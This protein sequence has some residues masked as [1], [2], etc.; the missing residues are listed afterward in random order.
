MSSYITFTFGLLTGLI[1]GFIAIAWLKAKYQALE[2]RIE[3]LHENILSSQEALATQQNENI[4]LIKTIAKLEAEKVS[5]E[6][7]LVSHQEKDKERGEKLS[8]QFNKLANELLKQ[9]SEK[10]VIENK[11]QI[12]SL[13]VPLKE[14]IV[15]FERQIT[16]THE[17]T[18]ARNIALRTELK[19]IEDLNLQITQEA[20]NL[21]N[22]IKGDNKVQGNWGEFILESLL[23]KSGLVKDREYFIQEAFITSEGKRYRPDVVIKLPD[24]KNIVIDAK[25]SLVNYEKCCN[26]ED[27]QEQKIYAKKHVHSIKTHIKDLSKKNYAQEYDLKGLDFVLM[28]IPIEPAYLLAVKH[29]TELFQEAYQKNI[30]LVTPSTLM[31]LLRMIEHTWKTD[32]QNKNA[33]EIARYSG[34]LFDKFVSFTE[35]IK[36]V[37]NQLNTTQKTYETAIKQLSE[38]KGN[39]ID[40][41]QR[42]KT[43]GARTNKTLL[44]P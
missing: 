18:L 26:E 29:E 1:T 34:D 38:G 14:K 15:T 35:N 24:G 41:V 27:P 17:E 16:R 43:L 36:K 21:T 5:L 7:N 30:V 40:K 8:L 12:E 37:G 10:L 28:F 4:S 6:K 25:V 9:G 23:E 42:L 44:S 2:A 39:L 13:L 20:K 31:G 32:N 3:A 19:K 22:A 33:L 11:T